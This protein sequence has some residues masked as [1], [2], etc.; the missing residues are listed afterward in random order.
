MK[1]VKLNARCIRRL[2]MYLSNW[3]RYRQPQPP[4]PYY[5]TMTSREDWQLKPYW[6]RI[7]SNPYRR[8]YH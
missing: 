4:P 1:Q 5:E 2:Y 3:Y 8:N 6:L 7:R